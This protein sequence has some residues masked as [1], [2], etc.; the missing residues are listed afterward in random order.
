MMSIS[1]NKKKDAPKRLSTAEHEA[2]LM[3]PSYQALVAE[4]IAL[5]EALCYEYGSLVASSRAADPKFD[6][7]R[8]LSSKQYNLKT[9][10]IQKRLREQYD[11][12]FAMSTCFVGPP[13]PPPPFIVDRV[14]EEEEEEDDASRSLFVPQQDSL[15]TSSTS[16]SLCS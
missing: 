9:A 11:A 14:R 10:L 4:V 8:R 13:P 7:F 1:L 2:A 6:D 5:Q 3:D 15:A 12:F 16:S